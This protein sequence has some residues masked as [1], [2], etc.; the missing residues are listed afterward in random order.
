MKQ[1]TYSFAKYRTKTPKLEE[2]FKRGLRL[3]DEHIK[4]HER[5]MFPDD[6]D[7]NN[8]PVWNPR[9]AKAGEDLVK[10]LNSLGQMYL[11]IQQVNEKMAESMSVEEQIE[12]FL[13][14]ASHLGRN[15]WYQLLR[16][17]RTMEKE[18]NDGYSNKSKKHD[19]GE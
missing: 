11:K 16:G 8:L 18:K 15:Q 10:S 3:L 17:F 13:E 19:P 12:A 1:G 5:A 6:C 7:K 2:T 4:R 9:L 14:W